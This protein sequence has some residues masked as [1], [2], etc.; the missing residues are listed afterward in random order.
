[1]KEAN[2]RN[3][4]VIDDFDFSEDSSTVGPPVSVDGI[5]GESN[6][7]FQLLKKFGWKDSEGLGKLRQGIVE[8]IMAQASDSSIGLGKQGE[9]DNLIA[10]ATKDRRRL[11]V[12]IEQ[13]SDVKRQRLE[14]GDRLDALKSELK[15]IN[16]EFYCDT[17]DKQYKNVKEMEN[18]LS[19]YDHHHR[20]RFKEMK[21]STA[22][23]A[24]DRNAVR[25]R[26]EQQLAREIKNRQKI[27]SS[28][29]AGKMSNDSCS[30]IDTIESVETDFIVPTENL[31]VSDKRGAISFSIMS[32]G[33]RKK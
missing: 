6:V 24:E 33:K 10:E 1:M 16:K 15:S 11:D 25:K 32:F 19:S 26:E 2:V 8:P 23:P 12:E 31:P 4:K 5:I 29:L 27:M 13:S 30:N 3:Q 21:Q 7:G 17:C 28:S 20:K 18:H 22:I 9:Y 14:N